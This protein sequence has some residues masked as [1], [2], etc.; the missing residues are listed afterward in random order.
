V[1]LPTLAD[2]DRTRFCY[3]RLRRL[4]EAIK[5]P[6]VIQAV[7]RE[8]DVTEADVPA[9]RARMDEL[10]AAAGSFWNGVEQPEIWAASMFKARQ[11][12]EDAIDEYFRPVANLQDLSKPLTEW[13]ALDGFTAQAGPVPRTGRANL[14]G[15]RGGGTISA[16]RTIGV[17][18]TN[19]PAEIAASLADKTVDNTH[20]A[21]IACTPATAAGF[22]WLR[23]T[24]SGRWDGEALQRELQPSGRGLLLV[25][26]DAIAQ[27]IP[28]KERKPEKALLQQLAVDLQA[29]RKP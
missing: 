21:Y 7:A 19:D 28:A 22:L 26:A 9:I 10:R 17:E 16:P 4:K 2:P 1:K 5:D 23:A 14:I 3:L 13:L 20:V 15:H 11:F 25:E 8:L 24:Q 27:A 6:R 29:T 12:A 18:A